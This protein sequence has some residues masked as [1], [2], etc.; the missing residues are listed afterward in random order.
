MCIRKPKLSFHNINENVLA[1]STTRNGGYGSGNYASGSIN[2]YCGDD[3][4]CVERNLMALANELH[5]EPERIVLP[6]Q[7][8]GTAVL[9]VSHDFLAKPL[10]ERKEALEGIDA[11]ITDVPNVCIGVSTADCVPILM[12]DLEHQAVCAAHAGWRGTVGRIVQKAVASMQEH[13]ATKPENLAVFIAPAISAECFEVGDEVFEAFEKAGFDM[14]KISFRKDKW[15]I[16]LPECNRLQLLE[17]G[18]CD[19]KISLCGICT[20]SNADQYFSARRLGTLCGRIYN[21]IMLR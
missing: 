16:D 15:H 12:Y 9:N 21:G 2:P 17:V 10:S 11:V 8:H 7:T 5:V 13:Y 6:H 14:P 3:P 4:F 20:Y 1:F 18:V 19:A